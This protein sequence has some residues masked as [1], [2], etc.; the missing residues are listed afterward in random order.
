MVSPSNFEKD[1]TAD[2]P[3]WRYDFRQLIT[4]EQEGNYQQDLI[5]EL[6]RLVGSEYD[7]NDPTTS[8]RALYETISPAIPQEYVI[9]DEHA[10]SGHKARELRRFL[11]DQIGCP[12]YDKIINVT[13]PVLAEFIVAFRA[14][15]ADITR[16][17]DAVPTTL[18]IGAEV[19][20]PDSAPERGR[21]SHYPGV[22]RD[23]IIE[24]NDGWKD[25]LRSWVD[26]HS[27]YVYVLDVTPPVDEERDDITLLRRHTR[28]MIRHG[29]DGEDLE[30]IYRGA[31]HLNNSDSVYY[32]GESNDAIGRIKDHL[33][34]AAFSG[35][36]FPHIFR[37]PQGVIELTGLE[38]NST[39]DGYSSKN[40]AETLE[41]QRANELSKPGRS[42]AYFN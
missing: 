29:L 15:D 28:A 3:G 19:F 12:P 11:S 18:P 22:D 14:M 36:E 26:D 4:A 9:H 8:V 32:V 39:V 27:W 33:Q 30:G 17:V 31:Y 34:G 41:E 23:S 40:A 7:A 2:T 35:S 10:S 21:P 1:A 6:N 16:P 13:N 42:W 24:L 20:I 25:R 38:V 5:D 37:P